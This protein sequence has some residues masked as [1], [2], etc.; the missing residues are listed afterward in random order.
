M[1]LDRGHKQAVDSLTMDEV[2]L[3]LSTAEKYYLEQY[4]LFL[5]AF[6]TGM[7]MGELLALKWGD[8]DWNSMFIRVERSFKNGRI[9]ETKTSRIRR[10]D[11][12]DQLIQSLRAYYTIRKAEALG[13][14]RGEVVEWIFHRNGEPMAQNSLRNIFKRI[15]RKAGMRDIRFHDIRHT[16]AS[17][18]LSNGE[19]PAY[20]KDQLGHSSIQITVDIY[21]HLLPGSNREAVNRLDKSAPSGSPM[22]PSIKE[23]RV[24]S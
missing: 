4:P 5:C 23:E 3:F 21:G 12:S 2:D 6:R 17:L 8:V 1:Q 18:L 9:S 24:T 11:M 13:S 19:S 20:V 14:G 10:V 7:R 15:L 22:A 16:Y